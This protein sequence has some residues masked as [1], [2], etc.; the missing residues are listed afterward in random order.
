MRPNHRFSLK[1]GARVAI[2]QKARQAARKLTEGV[3][4]AILTS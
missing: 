1:I 2:V 3:V 4:Q